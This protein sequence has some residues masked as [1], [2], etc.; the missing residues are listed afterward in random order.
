MPAEDKDAAPVAEAVM[1]AAMD[2]G[3]K[4][5]SMEDEATPYGMDLDQEISKYAE[6]NGLP[7]TWDGFL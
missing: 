2:M 3:M 5:P 6:T 4:M 7:D 1:D